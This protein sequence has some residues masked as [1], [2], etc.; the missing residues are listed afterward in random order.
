MIHV[1]YKFC[2]DDLEKD[3]EIPLY[4]LEGLEELHCCFTEWTTKREVI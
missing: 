4:L 1:N 2:L 3:S